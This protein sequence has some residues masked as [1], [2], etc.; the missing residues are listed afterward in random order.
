MK[1]HYLDSGYDEDFL[2]FGLVCGE[3][4]HRLAWMMNETGTFHFVR[5]ND[6]HFYGKANAEYFFPR[7][8]YTDEIN[9]LDYHLLGN[10]DEGQFLIPELRHV[11]YLLILK[12]AIDYFDA[13][14]F[15]QQTKNLET[16]QLVTEL[17]PAVLKSRENLIL[18]D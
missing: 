3:R 1:K 9:H 2:M 14:E 4:P 18:P 15:I 10:K 7:F 17:N 11:D 12:G 16:V 6:I 8:R 13:K 5:L